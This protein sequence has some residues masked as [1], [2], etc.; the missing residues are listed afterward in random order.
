MFDR[1]PRAITSML[2]SLFTL[3]ALAGRTA[4]AGVIDPGT[5]AALAADGCQTATG[6]LLG[7]TLCLECQARCDL[8][9]N[10]AETLVQL[11]NLSV[12][13]RYASAAVYSTFS[14]SSTPETR[15]NTVQATISY[16][17]FWQGGWTLNGVATGFNDARSTITVELVDVTEGR[18]LHTQPIHTQTPDGFIGIDIIEIGFGLDD[19]SQQSAFTA[20]LK[21][22]NEYR[23]R[24]KS[25]SE[26]KGAFNA[27]VVLDYLTGGWGVG[28]D[29]MEVA[30]EADLRELVEGL[31]AQIDSLRTDLRTHRHTYLTGRG[32]GHN[33]TEALTEVAIF[34][35]DDPGDETTL[36]D[37]P[38]A[39]L[40]TESRLDQN[41]PN[42]FNPTTIVSFTT[43]EDAHVRVTLYNVAGQEVMRLLDG[44]KPAGEHRVT[45]DA[46]GLASG[47]Y[48]YRL[49]AGRFVETRKMVVVK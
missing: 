1:R 45:V 16:D 42:P 30:V 23:V 37:E 44:V 10:V 47:V 14:V 39:P 9:A 20:T 13:K 18:V 2:V 36:P 43:P 19:G 32:E 34:F 29:Q 25:Y 8:P 12:G 27:F 24:L 48:F 4:T 3:I 28:W 7:E 35:D 15:G 22:G 33:N 46:S 11:S 41:F 31:Q 40:P 38:G 6:G 17:V 49:V 21:R 5:T 26:S